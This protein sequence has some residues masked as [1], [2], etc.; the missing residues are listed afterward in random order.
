MGWN[1]SGNSMPITRNTDCRW[2]ISGTT[3]RGWWRAVVQCREGCWDR[4][5]QL[6]AAGGQSLGFFPQN[7]CRRKMFFSVFFLN[8]GITADVTSRF[9]SGPLK[10]TVTRTRIGAFLRK[11]C[12]ARCDMETTIGRLPDELE[13]RTKYSIWVLLKLTFE[14]GV[15]WDQEITC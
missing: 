4:I 11:Q 8:I 15:T 13:F 10:S 14:G 3:V 12:F 1:G 7:L 5:W 9:Y 2:G 6:F